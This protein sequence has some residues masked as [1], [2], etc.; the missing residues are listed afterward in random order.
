MPQQPS[1]QAIT[2]KVIDASTV[3]ISTDLSNISDQVTIAGT[4]EDKPDIISTYLPILPGYSITGVLGRGGMGVV[5][6]ALQ[7]PINRPVALKMIISGQHAGSEDRLRFLAEAESIAKIQQPNIVQLYEFGNHEGHPYFALEYVTGGTLEKKLSS[8]P[9]PPRDAAILVEKLA[10]AM[11]KAHDLGIVHRDLKPANVLLTPAGEPKIADFGLAKTG[12]SN[13]TATGAILGTPSYMAPEQADGRKDVGAPTDIYALGAIL[14]ECLTGRPP[15]KAAT[16]LD[17]ILQVVNNDPVSVRILN[18]KVP[19]DLETIC[20]K[21]LA[22]L[23]KER[24]ASAKAMAE[25]LQHFLNGEG[26]VARRSSRVIKQASKEVK[27]FFK[28]LIYG[29][30]I[31]GLIIAGFIYY[32]RFFFV[33]EGGPSEKR[34]ALVRRLLTKDCRYYPEVQTE[35]IEAIRGDGDEAVRLATARSLLNG[36]CTTSKII[37]ALTICSNGS[38]RD[39]FPAERSSAVREAAKNAL[40]FLKLTAHD[41]SKTEKPPTK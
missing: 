23:P 2:E 3:Q 35:L 40:D 33:N 21:C 37:E 13:L 31:V 27:R 30:G 34:I 20:H 6:Q 14:Y 38:D 19:A 4:S 36:N 29:S 9:L 12:G 22:K 26:I 41:T 28:V 17:T 15:F 7:R 11:Q 10:R 18:K 24:Y 16:Q 39:G 1:L 5:Y 32:S 8:R 25:D